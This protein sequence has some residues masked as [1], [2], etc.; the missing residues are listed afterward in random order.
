MSQPEIKRATELFICSKLAA[1]L[2]ATNFQP[3]TGGTISDDA[4]ELEPPFAVVAV[5]AAAKVLGTEGTWQCQGTVQV[6]TMQSEATSEA[7][8]E[9]VRTIY[10][11]LADLAPDDTDPNFSFHGIDIGQMRSTQDQTLR[12]HADVI[13]F[14][15]G[16]GG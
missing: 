1:L 10:A 14:T 5:S 13:D 12:A 11:A 7:H 6:I 8:A 9:L 2:P 3:F 4:Q 16:V 15:A